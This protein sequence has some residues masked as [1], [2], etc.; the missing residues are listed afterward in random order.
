MD[1]DGSSSVGAGERTP[2]EEPKQDR[3][4]IME[5]PVMDDDDDPGVSWMEI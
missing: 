5:Y 4:N 1:D 2:R 3:T